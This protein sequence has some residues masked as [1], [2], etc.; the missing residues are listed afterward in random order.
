MSITVRKPCKKDIPLLKLLAL[1]SLPYGQPSR[2]K[3]DKV[4]IEHRVDEIFDE[5]VERQEHTGDI[6]VLVACDG[7]NVLGYLILLLQERDTWTG[8]EQAFI[9]DMAVDRRYWGKYIT[10]KLI[11]AA[12]KR[13]KEEGLLY[14]V[15]IVSGENQRALGTATKGLGFVI[16]RCQMVKRIE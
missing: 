12:V 4:L 3:P 14:L 16:E 13:A 6:E 11:N 1:E 15:G 8:E 5:L 9:Q 10:H 7:D 2:R